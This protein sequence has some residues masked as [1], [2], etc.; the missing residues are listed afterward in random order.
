MEHWKKYQANG[1]VS[2]SYQPKFSKDG[3][4]PFSVETPINAHVL[5]CFRQN[6]DMLFEVAY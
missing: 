3:K 2:P 6:G 5:G 4:K 1:G